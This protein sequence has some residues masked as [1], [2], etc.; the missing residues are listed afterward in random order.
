M[1]GLFQQV[2][3]RAEWQVKRSLMGA[4]GMAL[5]LIGGGFGVAAIWM[6]IEPHTGAIGA[7]LILG[8]VLCGAG[9]VVLSLRRT[10]PQP[11]DQSDPRHERR[12]QDRSK[13]M[14]RPGGL[15][16]PLMEAFLLGL[17]VYLE[18]RNRDRDR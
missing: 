10:T 1:P 17:S 2:R 3:Q 15:H 11:L 5:V 8:A 14:Y 9:L 12:T 7:S 4:I 13:G 18:Y 16:P 6:A